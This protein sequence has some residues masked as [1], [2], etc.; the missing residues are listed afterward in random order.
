MFGI[1]LEVISMLASTLLGG[2]MKMKAQGREDRA[3]QHKMLI[4]MNKVNAESTN[5]ARQMQNPSAAWTR[6]FIVVSLMAMAGFILVAPV[7]YNQ[8]TNVLTE[9][10]NGF[11]FLFFDFT[12]T[13]ESW[14][15]M[16]GVVTPDWLPYAIMN[17]LGFY[18]GT[19]AVSRSR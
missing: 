11:K 10:P 2:W 4:E 12:W 7:I 16:V 9:V 1:P 3:L 17:I 18:F 14:K 5:D 13:T 19:S 15:S 8:P 6:R